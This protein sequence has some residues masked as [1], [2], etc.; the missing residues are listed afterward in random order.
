MDLLVTHVTRDQLLADIIKNGGPGAEVITS[1][2]IDFNGTVATTPF[3]VTLPI[4]RVKLNSDYDYLMTEIRVHGNFGLGVTNVL[5]NTGAGGYCPTSEAGYL[6]FQLQADGRTRSVFKNPKL[7]SQFVSPSGNI[8]PMS[9]N[10]PVLFG[11]QET[12]ICT[13]SVAAGYASAVALNFGISLQF[14][15]IKVGA[16]EQFRAQMKQSGLHF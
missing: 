5:A 6:S 11:G 3:P 9:I 2:F 14:A 1:D 12:I 8:V 10:A 16:I 7:F 15:M 4:D 13:V